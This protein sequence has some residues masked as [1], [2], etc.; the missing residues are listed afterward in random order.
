MDGCVERPSSISPSHLPTS[1]QFVAGSPSRESMNS[2]ASMMAVA[3]TPMR[4]TRPMPGMEGI[5]GFFQAQLPHWQLAH[6]QVAHWQLAEARVPQSQVAHSKRAHW[7]SAQ[8]HGDASVLGEDGIAAWMLVE[9][10]VIR[11]SR[12]WL[13]KPGFFAVGAFST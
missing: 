1:R 8:P 10:D 7:Q 5:A 6:S 9:E 2:H 11:G 12:E 3:A 4:M 13:V